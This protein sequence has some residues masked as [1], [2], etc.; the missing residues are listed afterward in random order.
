MYNETF[1]ISHKKKRASKSIVAFT[2]LILLF[3]LSGFALANENSGELVIRYFALERVNGEQAEFAYAGDSIL[4]ATPGGKHILVDGGRPEVGSQVLARL[5]ELEVE[6]LDYVFATHPHV[7]HIGGF[8]TILQEASVGQFYQIAL[9]YDSS[10]YRAVQS[11][12]KQRN[13]PNATLEEGDLLEIEPGV[14]LEFFNP[15]VGTNLSSNKGLSTGGVNDLSLV[16]RLTYKD[17]SA[18]FTGDIYRA[19]EEYLVEKYGQRLQSRLYDAPHHGQDTS[20]STAFIRTVRPEVSVFSIE[21]LGSISNF[22]NLRDL[23]SEVYVTGLN[24]EV[25]IRTDGQEITVEVEEEINSP[26]LR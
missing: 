24:G 26:F 19:R 16:F 25:V 18:L 2:I 22:L 12:L 6:H 5:R 20:S 7:D 4:I 11:I 3:N 15:P 14:I 21:L 13:I 10:H 8:R 23:G 17:F 1:T 9:V